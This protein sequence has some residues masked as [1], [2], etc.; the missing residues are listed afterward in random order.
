P[1]SG[2]R[3]NGRQLAVDQNAVR[4]VEATTRGTGVCPQSWGDQLGDGGVHHRLDVQVLTR[5]G[6]TSLTGEVQVEGVADTRGQAEQGAQGCGVNTRNLLRAGGL[7]T[8]LEDTTGEHDTDDHD[9]HEH[10]EDR[11]NLVLIEDRR[12]HWHDD[13]LQVQQDGSDAGTNVEDRV[14]PGG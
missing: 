1:Q 9:R 3:I 7:A 12:E 8:A 14:V 2:L 11:R 4:E 6:G 5:S 10:Q 13:H